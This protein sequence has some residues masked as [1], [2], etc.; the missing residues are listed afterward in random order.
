[1]IEHIE[2]LG[3]IFRTFRKKASLTQEQL[4][5][6]AKQNRT[7]VALLEQG[8]RLPSPEALRGL[9]RILDIPDDIWTP[10]ADDK[11]S[12]RHEFES[13]LSELLGCKTVLKLMHVESVHAAERSIADLFSGNLTVA[14]AHDTLN[15]VLVY[16]G[17]PWMTRR[18]FDRFFGGSAF[19]SVEAFKKAVVEYQTQAIRLFSTFREAYR[20]LNSTDQLSELLKPLEP[21]N[22]ELYSERTVWERH[23]GGVSGHKISMIEEKRLPYLG[24]ISVDAYR[25]QRAKRE[26]LAKYLRELAD[27][28]RREGPTAVDALTEKKRRKIDSLVHELDS[29]LRHTP[30]SS[31]FTPN[32]AE[33]EAEASRILRDESDE[34]EMASTQSEALTNLSNYV[35]ADFMDVYVATSMRT[36][37]DFIAVNRFVVKLFKHDKVSPLRLRYFNPTQSWIDDRVAKGLVEALMLRRASLT[38]YMAQKSDTFGKDSEAS[39]ALG[40]GK[41][42]VVYVPKLVYSQTEIDSE[43]LYRSSDSQLRQII[44][45][46]GEGEEKEPDEDLDHDGL[47]ALALT[48][49]LRLLDNSDL[50]KV[51]EVHWADFGLLD[52][53]DRIRGERET[54]RREEYTKYIRATAD[55]SADVISGNLRQDVLNV[56]VALIV[57]FE[58]RAKQFREVHPLALQVI[59]S[60]GVL[61][62]ILVARSIDSCATVIRGLIENRLELSLQMDDDNYRLIEVTTGSTIR[63]IS[64]NN[65]LTNAFDALYDRL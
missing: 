63:V 40:Q 3:F 29:K 7:V 8:R 2:Q 30:M 45:A 9:A 1:M 10:F 58:K 50:T 61:N 65:L 22:I 46:K 43:V 59:L 54:E 5:S 52:E 32:P 13:A 6:K 57:N 25:K 16:Y 38:V 44:A 35:S 42:V 33:L 53:T 26:L 12:Q 39:V 18:F 49:Q 21:K 20:R 60:T 4:A 47:Y 55:G 27:A 62:G 41:P 31:L 36:E 34:A 19:H 17:I 14:Q 64:R 15:S 51:V 23:N 24:Y 37:S 48:I 28:V 11:S 56:L